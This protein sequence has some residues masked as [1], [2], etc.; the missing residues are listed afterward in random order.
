MRTGL[1]CTVHVYTVQHTWVW[2]L[3][4]SS[5]LCSPYRTS[6]CPAQRRCRSL[7]TQGANVSTGAHEGPPGGDDNAEYITYEQDEGKVPQGPQG[8]DDNAE[9]ITYEQD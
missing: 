7:N 8:G 2:G 6:A 1:Q 4:Q 5:P 3:G 9:Y